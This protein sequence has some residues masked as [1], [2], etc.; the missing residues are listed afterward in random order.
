MTEQPLKSCQLPCV[1]SQLAHLLAIYLGFVDGR[2]RIS[3]RA[4]TAFRR[5]RRVRQPLA[6][7]QLEFGL[8]R[9]KTY[10][11][12]QIRIIRGT[13]YTHTERERERQ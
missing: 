12:F 6:A 5:G 13:L 9:C 4:E 3:A 11:F 2:T 7:K 1:L 8:S 10:E